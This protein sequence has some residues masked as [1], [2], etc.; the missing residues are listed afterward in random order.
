MHNV[1]MRDR[2]VLVEIAVDGSGVNRHFH[3]LAHWYGRPYHSLSE[4]NP[5]NIASV[6]EKVRSVIR[7]IDIS[8]Y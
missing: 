6:I 2:G 8:K 3:N 1:F 5:L 7:S 4:S